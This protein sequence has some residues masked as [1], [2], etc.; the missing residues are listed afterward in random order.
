MPQCLSDQTIRQAVHQLLSEIQTARHLVPQCL[1]E[2][3]NQTNSTPIV[4]RCSDSQKSSASMPLRVR[5]SDKQHISCCQR[6]RQPDIQC[7]GASQSQTIRK[8]VFQIMS[9]VQTF[10]QLMCQN[11]IRQSDNQ[12]IRQS[13]CLCL[14]DNQHSDNQKNCVPNLVN[15]QTARQLVCQTISGADDLCANTSQPMMM[16]R[17]SD[18]LCT[19]SYQAIRTYRAGHIRLCCSNNQTARQFVCYVGASGNASNI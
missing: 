3:D 15:S 5:Q 1:S 17:H 13:V 12:T 11:C 16:L 4:V 9:D 14:S 19:S 7:L 6:H 10:R 8:K 18:S 2:S